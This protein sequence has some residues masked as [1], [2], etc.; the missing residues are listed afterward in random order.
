[1]IFF[2]GQATKKG[3]TPPGRLPAQEGEYALTGLEFSAFQR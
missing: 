1:M 3:E 2:P